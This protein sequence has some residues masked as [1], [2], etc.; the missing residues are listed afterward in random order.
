ML[1]KRDNL[2][3]TIGNHV[4]LLGFSGHEDVVDAGAIADWDYPP[5]QATVLNGCLYGRG[6]VI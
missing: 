4:P 1:P 2:V 3:V 5:F 6:Q